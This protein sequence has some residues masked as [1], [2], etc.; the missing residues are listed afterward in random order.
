MKPFER[1]TAAVVPHR[2]QGRLP[3]R[4][5]GAAL[6]VG[7]ILLLV[8]TLLGVSNMNMTTIELKMAA[9]TQNQNH[10]F[11]VAEAGIGRSVNAATGQPYAVNFA[12]QQDQPN[13]GLVADNP[14]ASATVGAVFRGQTSGATCPGS[15]IR[16]FSCIHFEIQ[17]NG[18]HAASGANCQ[19]VQ[20]VFRVAPKPQ[21]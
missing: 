16:K 14:Y 20:G 4:Q 12:T 9:N 17:S 21:S 15:S 13:I 7:L 8:L 3:G 18:T 5:Q 11:Q 19:N 1:V 10:C 6:I 2:F